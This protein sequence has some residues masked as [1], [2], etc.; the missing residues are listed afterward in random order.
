M[1]AI[2]ILVYFILINIGT[3]QSQKAL[4]IYETIRVDNDHIRNKPISVEELD[5][6]NLQMSKHKILFHLLVNDNEAIYQAEYDLPTKRELGFG[7]DETAILGEHEKVFYSNSETKDAFYRSFWTKNILVD[8]EAMNWNLINETKE[9]EGYLCHKAITTVTE[10]QPGGMNFRSPIEVWYTKEIPISFGIKNWN[11][12]PGLIM[13]AHLDY[14]DGEILVK[15]NEINY[16]F[17]GNIDIVKPKGK[18]RIG[19]PEYLVVLDS[20]NGKRF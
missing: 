17:K 11:G 18:E 12:L 13:E 10:E 6:L 16:P 3:A 8:T 14:D 9:I 20:L 7:F 5:N 1:K 2:Q 19:L 4:I 15:V